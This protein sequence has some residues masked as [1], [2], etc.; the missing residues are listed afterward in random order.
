MPKIDLGPIGAVINPG[1]DLAE[2][3]AAID[4]LGYSTLWVTGGPMERLGQLADAF[5]ATKAARVAS[6]IIPVIRFPADDVIALYDELEAEGPAGSWSAWV[7]P[8]ARSRSTRSTPTST[9]STVP[10][11]PPPGG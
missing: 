8:T 4:G 7:V 9:G 5:R 11:S 2:T 1:P 3:A 6:G 10:A